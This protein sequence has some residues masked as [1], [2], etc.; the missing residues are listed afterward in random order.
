MHGDASSLYP[1]L[2]IVR[3]SSR[4]ANYMYQEKQIS[5]KMGDPS[6]ID[7]WSLRRDE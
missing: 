2:R 5:T 6:L 1:I 3:S 7:I 4:I